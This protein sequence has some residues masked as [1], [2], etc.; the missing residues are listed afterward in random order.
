M[1]STPYPTDAPNSG[2]SPTPPPNKERILK[3]VRDIPALPEV[4]T[5]VVDLLNKASSSGSQIADLISYDPGLTSR[6]L[7]MVN[8][9]AYGIPRQVTSIQHSIAMLG[10]NAV[11]GLVLG[12]SIC[13]IFS[14]ITANTKGKAVPK[15]KQGL[16]LEEFWRH[17]L[18]TAFFAKRLA[19]HF[20]LP[21]ADDIFSAGMLHNIGVLVLHTQDAISDTLVHNALE[22]KKLWRYA[23]QALPIEYSILGFTHVD[24]GVELAQRW[25]LP[26]VMLAVMSRYNRPRLTGNE[27][28]SAVFAV[29]LAHHL[30]ALVFQLDYD[31]DEISCD[32]LPNTLCTFFR[33]EADEDVQALCGHIA[34]LLEESEEIMRSL[35]GG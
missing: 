10:Y 24:L 15:N 11:R 31:F 2:F 29:A 18:M 27:T 21:K 19:E 32:H 1:P 6:I 25:Q 35:I 16:D 9:S 7:R 28:D 5:Q 23:P 4:V 26:E 8:S 17:A 14:P 3:G 20:K 30:L 13:Q 33:L 22:K 12:A 34:P